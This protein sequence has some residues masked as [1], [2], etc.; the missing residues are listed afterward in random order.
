MTDP[1]RR[2]DATGAIRHQPLPETPKADAKPPLTGTTPRLADLPKEASGPSTPIAS[3]A[4]SVPDPWECD[5]EIVKFLTSG[6]EPEDEDFK[7]IFEQATRLH[8]DGTLN[9]VCALLKQRIQGKTELIARCEALIGD[10]ESPGIDT[11]RRTLKEAAE[12]LSPAGKPAVRV[13]PRPETTP[14][15]LASFIQRGAIPPP[16]LSAIS[17][18]SP[19]QH[20]AHDESRQS[21]A[22]SPGADQ[23]QSPAASR[24][25]G[26]PLTVTSAAGQLSK[27]LAARTTARSLTELAGNAADIA[28]SQTASEAELEDLGQKL[29]ERLIGTLAAKDPTYSSNQTSMTIRALL[30]PIEG[31]TEPSDTAGLTAVM[32]ALIDTLEKTGGKDLLKSVSGELREKANQAWRSGNSALQENLNELLSRLPGGKMEAPP[33]MSK[34][35]AKPSTSSTSSTSSQPLAQAPRFKPG[36][37]AA[38]LEYNLSTNT[39]MTSVDCAGRL[40]ELASEGM[41]QSDLDHLASLLGK[42]IGGMS[43]SDFAKTSTKRVASELLEAMADEDVSDDTRNKL[44]S[45]LQTLSKTLG[46]G[47]STGQHAAPAIITAFEEALEQANVSTRAS[48]QLHLDSFKAVPIP[49]AHA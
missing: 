38:T 39:R 2:Q 20:K 27:L 30:E 29:A 49:P 24:Q 17:G 40:A 18:M 15:P 14:R 34:R 23:P 13:V 4:V 36:T 3:R 25:V 10:S 11:I 41:Q 28:K 43:D 12:Q 1:T 26:Q 33:L 21:V 37:P 45:V 44:A 6:N 31:Q 19:E 8:E 42:R 16:M 9:E 46:D 32:H 48:L 7:N 5:V 35:N 22:A 47:P